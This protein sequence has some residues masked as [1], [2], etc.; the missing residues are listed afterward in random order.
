MR[1]LGTVCN[2]ICDE[3]TNYVNLLKIKCHYVLCVCMSV[4]NVPCA[5]TDTK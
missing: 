1:S 5:S 3:K 2:L 4:E